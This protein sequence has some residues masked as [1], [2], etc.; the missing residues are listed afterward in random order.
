MDSYRQIKDYFTKYKWT[1]LIFTWST[2]IIYLHM[3]YARVSNPVSKN[4]M[5]DIGPKRP[6]FKIKYY[7]VL[8]N[9]FMRGGS[10]LTG[11]VL[12]HIVD[13]FYLY[14]PLLKISMWTYWHGYS[15]VCRSNR[16]EC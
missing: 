10:T 7:D 11:M 5:E 13:T 2:A 12:G 6:I 9:S 15:M 8:L 16:L 1:L 4:R 14:E 3:Q